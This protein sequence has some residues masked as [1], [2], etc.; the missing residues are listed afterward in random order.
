MSISVKDFISSTMAFSASETGAY[1]ML[2][3]EYWREKKLPE[4]DASLA[5]IVKMRRSEWLKVKTHIMEMFSNRPW[6]G[7]RTYAEIVLGIG[8]V[9]RRTSIPTYIRRQVIQRDG[10]TCVYC[11]AYDGPF[12]LDHVIPWSRGGGHSAENLVVACQSCNR[13]KGARFLSEWQS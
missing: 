10:S 4:D 13:S 8:L 12:D 2:L 11:G 6:N 3:I 9:V 7:D 1:I 5:E